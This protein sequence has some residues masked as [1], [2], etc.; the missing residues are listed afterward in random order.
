LSRRLL[1]E[2]GVKADTSMLS[3]FFRRSAPAHAFLLHRVDNE[4]PQILRIGLPH[5]PASKRQSFESKTRGL[6]NPPIHPNVRVL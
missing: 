3:R 4:I 6:G 5:A 1:A 2:R